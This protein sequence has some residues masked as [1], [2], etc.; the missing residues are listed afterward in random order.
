MKTIY[1]VRVIVAS[2]F[3]SCLA[4]S[5]FASN[6]ISYSLEDL[7]L[8]RWKAVY[9]VQNIN[10]INP[11]QEFT[12]W[13]DYGLYSNLSIETPS[14]LNAA[15]NESIYE[16]YQLPPLSPFDGY[17]DALAFDSGI[18]AGQLT[19]GFTITFDWLG[20]GS[21]SA[22]RYEVIDPG[23]FETVA[24]GQTVYIP[25]PGCLLLLLTG[26]LYLKKRQKN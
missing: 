16:P 26:A 20:T 2:T 8:G 12:L 6:Q 21:P 3:L 4:C 17:Y 25:E 22:Q 13:F 1:F 23:T 7:G 10:L 15:W 14:P 9:E 19:T 18:T 24:E 5:L 11:I